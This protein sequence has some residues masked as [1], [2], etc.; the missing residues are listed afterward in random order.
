MIQEDAADMADNWCTPTHAPGIARPAAGDARA[1]RQQAAPS[2]PEPAQQP[3]LGS[4]AG[5]DT[6]GQQGQ[7]V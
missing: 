3:P 5:A 6:S 2:K 7:T 1:R 4:P